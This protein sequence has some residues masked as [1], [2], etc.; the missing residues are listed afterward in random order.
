VVFISPGRSHMGNTSHR[1]P[2]GGVAWGRPVSLIS[3]VKANE[4]LSIIRRKE[5]AS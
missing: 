4:I 5:A 1:P 3:K 2:K